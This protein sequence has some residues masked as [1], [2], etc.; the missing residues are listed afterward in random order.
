MYSAPESPVPHLQS[1]KMDIFSF[2]VLMLETMVGRFPE[3]CER[4]AMMGDIKEQCW[5][6]LIRRCMHEDRE[7]RPSAAHIITLISAWPSR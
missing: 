5:V 6:D 7:Q 3:V 4:E 1:P 2:G